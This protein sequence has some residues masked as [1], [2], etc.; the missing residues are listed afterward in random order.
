MK[1]ILSILLA[2]VMALGAL[3]AAAF[4]A[5]EEIVVTGEE[6]PVVTEGEEVPAAAEEDAD[7]SRRWNGRRRCGGRQYRR[8]RK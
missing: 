2:L 5:E 1:R 4:A 3:P 7:G 6:N 8:Q